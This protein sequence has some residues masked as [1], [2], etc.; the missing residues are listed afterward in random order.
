M[1]VLSL[2]APAEAQKTK[3]QLNAEVSTTFPDNSTGQITPLGV[4]AFQ[5]DVIN[6]I[7]PTAPVVNGNFSCFNG[8]TGLLQDCGTSPTGISIANSNL[9]AGS[10]NTVKGSL[11]GSTTSDIA[12]VSCSLLYQFTQWVSGT[13]WQCGV[14]P[15]LPSR[16]IAAT[17]NLSAFSAIT[18]QGY[19]TPGDGGG[20]TFIKIAGP[21]AFI[22]SYVTN[23]TFTAG[24]GYTDGTYLGVPFNVG[25]NGAVTVSSGVVTAVSF[26]V[27]CPKETVGLVFTPN[28]SFVGGSGSGF[29]VTVTGIST[30]KAS[31]ADAV[32]NLFQFVTDQAGQANILQF[33]AKADWNGSDASATNNSPAIW[34]AAAWASYPVATASAQVFGNK[35]IF[36]R[37]AYM[38]CGGWNGTIYDIPIP[39]G[40]VFDGLQIGIATLRECAADGSGNHY[41]ELCDSNSAVGQSNCVIQNITIDGSA[42]TTSTNG[43]AM[44]YSNSGQQFTL[45]QGVFINAGLRGCVK[46]E[47]GKGGAANDIWIGLQCTQNGGAINTGFS[48]NAGSTQHIIRDTVFACGGTGINCPIA[49]THSNGRLI[50]EN[51]DI[52]GFA[53]ALSQNVGTS[54]NLSIFKNVQQNSTSCTA[55][56]QITAGNTAGNILFENV[57]TSCPLTIQNNQ[58]GGSNFTGNILKPITCVSGAC[59]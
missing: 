54:G 35:I 55:V 41:I 39:A 25:C 48:L 47:I 30:A 52:E 6:S 27:P 17:L 18:T 31:F 24:S 32:G 22:D 20:A 51:L 12:I 15:V 49:I 50:A 26:A 34:S 53:F 56:I 5:H 13:G 46:Y 44:I 2:F 36:P 4:Q 16:A 14:I 38:T 21:Q 33:G 43:T 40:V 42:L 29:S 23:F 59:S 7:M 19:A 57:A 58:S 37:G 1:L 28:N 45:A 10:A 11:N 3:A 9:V 8:T